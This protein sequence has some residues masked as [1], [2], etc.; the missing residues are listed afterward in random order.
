MIKVPIHK[1]TITVI[2]TYAPNVRT[3]KFIK[4]I[5]TDPKSEED[6]NTVIVGKISMPPS[7]MD[8]SHRQKINKET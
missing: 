5:L 8:R 7:A 3:P 4:Q 1:E 2:K 6:D